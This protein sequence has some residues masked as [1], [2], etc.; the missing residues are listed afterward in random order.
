MTEIT[1]E[2]RPDLEAL[3]L[4]LR[5]TCTT[6]RTKKGKRGDVFTVQG[7]RF[8][9][10]GVSRVRLEEVA[11]SDYQNEGCS[12]PDEFRALWASIYGEYDGEQR[13]WRHYFFV[14]DMDPWDVLRSEAQAVRAQIE[15]EGR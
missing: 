10:T 12:S 9:L 1:I 15:R 14:E 5:K 8:V 7:R 11:R 4:S 13:V 6:R 3:V 2:F